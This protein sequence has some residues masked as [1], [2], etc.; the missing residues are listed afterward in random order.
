MLLHVA[1]GVGADRDHPLSPV[2][3]NIGKRLPEQNRREILPLVSGV[4]F[5]VDQVNL[6][7]SKAVVHQTNAILAEIDLVALIFFRVNDFW[8]HAV[9][10][11]A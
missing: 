4:Y 6:S 3:A 11:F 1:N 7:G 8:L 9:N 10:L 5:G 2:G